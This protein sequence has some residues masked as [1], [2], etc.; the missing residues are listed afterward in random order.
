M[1][2]ALVLGATGGM[3]YAIVSE[4]NQRGIKTVAFAR[5]QSKLEKLFGTYSFVE[6]VVGD[7]F[8]KEQMITVASGVDV[9]FHAINIPYHRWEEDQPTIVRNIVDT[10]KQTGAKLA[11]VDNIYAYGRGDG[12]LVQ[13]TTPK[14]PHTKKGKIRLELEHMAFKAN[15]PVLVAHFPDYYGPNAENTFIHFLL[16]DVL[17]NKRASYVGNTAIARE[18]LYTPDGARAIV[19]LSLR[20]DAYGQN[21]N[22]PSAGSISGE[23]ILQTVRE[24]TGYEKKVSVVTKNMIRMVGLFNPQMRELTEMMYLNE[25]PVVLSGHKFESKVGPVPKTP[26]RKGLEQTIEFMKAQ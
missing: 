16:K 12:S 1:K 20:E 26:Y 25:Q 23:D 17:Q 11:M 9:I 15:V 3:G 2:K 19:E 22:I 7:V 14:R 21:W 18:F 13:E 24:L 10:A 5:N 6:C 8:Q 4:L